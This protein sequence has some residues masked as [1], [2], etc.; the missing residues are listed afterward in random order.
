MTD[1]VERV[2][3]EEL[4]EEEEPTVKASSSSSSLTGSSTALK[5]S[6]LLSHFIDERSATCSSLMAVQQELVCSVC[7]EL[8]NDP[9]CLD[10]GHNVC[11][12]CAHRLVAFAKACATIMPASVNQKAEA[13]RASVEQ[14]AQEAARTAGTIL[15]PSEENKREKEKENDTVEVLKELAEPV[16]PAVELTCP[17]CRV[18]TRLGDVKPNIVLR[19]MVADLRLRAPPSFM[20]ELRQ[21]RRALEKEQEVLRE[22]LRLRPHCGFCDKDATVYCADCGSLCAEHSAYLHSSGPL[23]FHDLSTAISPEVFCKT[24]EIIFGADSAA[25]FGRDFQMPPCPEHGK[26]TELF[27]TKCHEAV[28]MH[29]LLIG[30]HREHECIS[31]VEAF[32]KLDAW[33]TEARAAV[34]ELLPACQ[35]VADG[36]EGWARDEAAQREDAQ[37]EVHAT[38]ARLL[39]AAE[40]HERAVCE[41]AQT[42]YDSFDESSRKRTE[43]LHVVLAHARELLAST[44]AAG[45]VSAFAQEAMV[46]E[47]ASEL[48]VLQAVAK[49]APKSDAAVLTVEDH[50]KLLL[51]KRLVGVRRLYSFAGGRNSVFPIKIDSLLASTSE[52]SELE[53]PNDSSHDGGAVI[54]VERR[55]IVHVSG[56]CNN[57]RDIFLTNIDTKHTERLNNAVPYRT[58]GQYPVFDGQNRVYFFQSEQDSNDRF[59]YFD[60]ETRTF[61]ELAK[62]PDRFREFA[63]PCFLDG[64][65]YAACRDKYLWAYDV[66][67]ETWTKQSLR[68]GKCRLAADPFTHSIAM[69][70]KRKKFELY[71]L[72]TKEVT[73]YPLPP[74][75]FS[76]GSNQE[77]VFL[78]T[79]PEA[80]VCIVSLDSHSMY[81]FVSKTNSWHRLRWKDVRNGSAHL[82]FDP[83]TSAF[84]YHIDSKSYITTVHVDME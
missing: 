9:V 76:L 80:F 74:S 15:V 36:Y 68:V 49:S 45:R 37:R 78:R 24:R 67:N 61:T 44:A 53:C 17:L 21:E 29:C 77:M 63:S 82:V 13:A 83:V 2:P 14:A 23:R 20:P 26:P 40:G 41:H 70:K 51:D 64:C 25:S 5:T 81:A 62:C 73:P 34:T 43:G 65:I 30:A 58:H 66:A 50:R 22:Q 52:R 39:A 42:L 47:L 56:N 4:P 11:Y 55:L 60:L 57:G 31:M 72:E 38:F 46:R 59:G 35:K 54:D 79:C 69:I 48:A 16:E 10:C 6:G 7:L 75:N 8:F 3:T 12:K 27:C 1:P 28:C 19:N 18:K 33:I 32:G 84:Y 71:S